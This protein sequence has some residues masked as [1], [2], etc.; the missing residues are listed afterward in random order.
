MEVIYLGIESNYIPLKPTPTEWKSELCTFGEK[1]T[2]I[3]HK[4]L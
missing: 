4:Y 2:Q 3:R 1:C